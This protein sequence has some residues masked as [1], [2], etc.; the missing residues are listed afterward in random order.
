MAALFALQIVIAITGFPQE[1]IEDWLS[2][3]EMEIT[4]PV[5]YVFVIGSTIPS[6]IG[7]M[8]TYYAAQFG[9]TQKNVKYIVAMPVEGE[10]EES[11]AWNL[12]NELLL[13]GID[14]Q[15]ILFETT[16]LNTFYQVAATR[17]MLGEKE[18]SQP[19]L[20][21]TAPLHMRRTFL[22]FQEQGFHNVMVLPAEE[23]VGDFDLG[24]W[25]FF[26]YTFWYRLKFQG[27]IARELVALGGYKL[28][29]WI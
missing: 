20:I 26:R 8:N 22:C 19:L 7:L 12:R 18:L 16:G 21:V 11:N 4:Q 27:M 28:N 1:Q 15:N 6:R 14:T 9:A 25:T 13:R 10:L 23:E 29:G 3:E 24:A 2:C 5:K 17:K